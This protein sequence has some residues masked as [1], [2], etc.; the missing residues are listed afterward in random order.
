MVID[1]QG[2]QVQTLKPTQG[3][4]AIGVAVDSES[5]GQLLIGQRG[6][7][8]VDVYDKNGKYLKTVGE[9][10]DSLWSDIVVGGKHLFVIE[11]IT[12]TIK[13]YRLR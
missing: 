11:Y 6:K 2:K 10:K 8:L 5:D 13:Q 4:Y 12:A 1:V 3:T 7:S 9:D